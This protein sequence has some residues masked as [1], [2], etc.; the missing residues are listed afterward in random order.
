MSA[1]RD[2]ARYVVKRL[3]RGFVVPF[4][5]KHISLVVEDADS[6]ASATDASGN[7]QFKRAQLDA[8]ALAIT[9]RHIE[10]IL[11]LCPDLEAQFH[12]DMSASLP[13]ALAFLEFCNNSV[14]LFVQQS[15]NVH[16]RRQLAIL[17]EGVDTA[18]LRAHVTRRIAI[19]DLE[20]GVV[21]RAA[22]LAS[23]PHYAAAYIGAREEFDEHYGANPRFLAEA[24]QA[25]DFSGDVRGNSL[26]WFVKDNIDLFRGKTILHIAPE[27]LVADYF[28]AHAREFNVRY[29]TCDGFSS[30]VDHL[31]DIT[32]LPMADETYDFVLCHRVLEHVLDDRAALRENFRILRPGGFLNISVPQSMNRAITAE[33]LAQDSTHHDHVR[34]YGR[35]FA[36]RLVAIGFDVAVDET[37][38][39][40]SLEDHRRDGTY[41]MRQ[42][43]CLKPAT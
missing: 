1:A 10:E 14:G 4:T 34:Q 36:D 22:V 9:I 21:E 20:D 30:T 25:L 16:L 39:N 31:S 35:D 41:P 26:L 8:V 27:H 3:R 28:H 37:L 5:A 18:E 29:E 24:C 15:R 42:Y 23:D 32:T 40:R 7:E 6:K 17:R 11:R 2:V 43:L 33:W 13:A 38:L 19:H 12:P